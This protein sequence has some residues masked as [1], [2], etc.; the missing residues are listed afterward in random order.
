MKLKILLVSVLCVGFG[1]FGY[2]LN[3]D[4]QETLKAHDHETS[5]HI[6][7][8]K[9]PKVIPKNKEPEKVQEGGQ[10]EPKQEPKPEPE[11]DKKQKSEPEPQDMNEGCDHPGVQCDD[12]KDEPKEPDHKGEDSPKND[13]TR[14]HIESLTQEERSTL[15]KE[16]KDQFNISGKGELAS[17]IE[18]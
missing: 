15:P 18:G 12:Q 11:T 1:I 5:S 4:D 17:E 2:F 14:E 9:Q 6:E 7:K 8:E 3:G 16:I 10:P 13:I